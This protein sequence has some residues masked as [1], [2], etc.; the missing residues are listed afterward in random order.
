[1]QVNNKTNCFVMSKMEKIKIAFKVY[2]TSNDYRE[3]CRIADISPNTYYR[4]RRRFKSYGL[5]RTIREFGNWSYGKKPWNK[6]PDRIRKKIEIFWLEKGNDAAGLQHI[7]SRHWDE[8]VTRFNIVDQDELV[9][10]IKEAVENGTKG[11]DDQG[12]TY[13]HYI[14]DGKDMVVGVGDNGFIVTARPGSP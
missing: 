7:L 11:I 14:K 2:K 4:W 6:T 1:M 3:A 12:R 5:Q 9:K 10:L 13:Y 8:F